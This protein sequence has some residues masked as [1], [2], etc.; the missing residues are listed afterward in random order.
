MTDDEDLD[1]AGENEPSMD[2]TEELWRVF[3]TLP[4]MSELFLGMQARNIVVVD[5]YLRE[6]ERQV[7]GVH[8]RE[9][10]TPI[11]ELMTLSA[12]S[13]LWV[14]GLYELLRTWRQRTIELLALKKK[15]DAAPTDEDRQV[16]ILEANALGE[17]PSGIEGLSQLLH[18]ER[19][20]AIATTDLAESL[21]KALELMD[22]PYRQL[23]ILR[24]TLAKHEIPK[25]GKR[26]IPSFSPGY[27][28]Q[29]MLDGSLTWFI[30]LKD[31][32]QQLISRSELVE[33]LIAAFR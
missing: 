31:G 28:R 12:F 25:T 11:E 19:V 2:P 32:S 24:V 26:S 30:E 8:I 9:E 23:E 13:Q 22:G 18:K 10:R 21:A 6:M 1:R 29:N 15:L 3:R 14:F 17:S 33:D 4:L 7:L 27:A 20:D 16:L 5:Q